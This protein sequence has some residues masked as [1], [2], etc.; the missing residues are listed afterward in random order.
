MKC[1]AAGACSSARFIAHLPL[2][3]SPLWA[4]PVQASDRELRFSYPQTFHVRVRYSWRESANRGTLYHA[5]VSARLMDAFLPFD[6]VYATCRGWGLRSILLP[7]CPAS[8]Y[9]GSYEARKMSNLESI[10]E[11]GR[12]CAYSSLRRKKTPSLFRCVPV[13][14]TG[15]SEQ[16]REAEPLQSYEAMY[17]WV[18]VPIEFVTGGGS[19]NRSRKT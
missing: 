14:A 11:T 6:H 4:A 19:I 18:L 9:G 3:R 12:H 2:N 5:G 7:S 1:A 16:L 17:S 13:H 10:L 8:E 15:D